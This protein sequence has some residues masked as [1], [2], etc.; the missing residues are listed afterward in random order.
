MSWYDEV[1]Y[2]RGRYDRDRYEPRTAAF[3]GPGL[4]SP[5]L[6]GGAGFVRWRER[7]AGFTSPEGY[8]RRGRYGYDYGY[9]RRFRRPRRYDRGWR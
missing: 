7:P 5:G 1:R 2:F 6:L 8:G 4:T 9:E 3:A